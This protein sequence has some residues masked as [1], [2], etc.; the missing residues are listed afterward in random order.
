MFIW[1]VLPMNEGWHITIIFYGIQ[2]Q[3][4]FCIAVRNK[5]SFRI[6]FGMKEKSVHFVSIGR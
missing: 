4:K 3:P 1:N 2:L 6:G 5:L